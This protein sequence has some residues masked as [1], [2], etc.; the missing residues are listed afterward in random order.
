MFELELDIVQTTNTVRVINTWYYYR[1]YRS[2]EDEK[3]L[4][5]FKTGVHGI[6]TINFFRSI[7]TLL[8]ACNQCTV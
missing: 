1:P 7:Q 2:F 4:L 6:A 3:S 8:S 5:K